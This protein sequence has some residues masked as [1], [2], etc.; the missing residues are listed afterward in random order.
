MFFLPNLNFCLLGWLLASSPCRSHSHTASFLVLH[1]CF[2]PFPFPPPLQSHRCQIPFSNLFFP[3]SHFHSV[4]TMWIMKFLSVVPHCKGQCRWDCPP[5]ADQAQTTRSH[6]GKKA[7][8]KPTA[9]SELAVGHRSSRSA[10][11][12]LNAFNR[13]WH[14]CR[15]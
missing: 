1:S 12:I 6:C 9:V 3:L 15:L 13:G 11:L 10:V 5:C 4:L 7:E 2:P 8:R 14:F